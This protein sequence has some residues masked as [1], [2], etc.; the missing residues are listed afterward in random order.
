MNTRLTTTTITTR[1]HH[2]LKLV[3]V[4]SQISPY[5]FPEYHNKKRG[6][7]K[8]EKQVIQVE[9]GMTKKVLQ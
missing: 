3:E 5:Q 2:N 6:E 1:L 7:S 4:N 8:R 9:L